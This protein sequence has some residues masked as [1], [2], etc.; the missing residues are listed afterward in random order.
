MSHFNVD[1]RVGWLNY[2]LVGTELHRYHHSADPAEAKN[3][4]AVVSIWDQVFGTFVYRPGN[5]PRALGVDEPRHYP[6]DTQLLQ[7]LVH[8]LRGSPSS[9]G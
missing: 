8:P 4:G 5:V 3:F 9:A 6:A 1:S 7:V 2:L